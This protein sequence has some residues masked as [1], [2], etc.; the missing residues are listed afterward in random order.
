MDFVQGG[1][2]VRV[3]GALVTSRFGLSGYLAHAG[4]RLFELDLF[5]ERFNDGS[6]FAIA[7]MAEE[8]ANVGP[9]VHGTALSHHHLEARL[10]SS[11]V[12]HFRIAPSFALSVSLM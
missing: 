3:I 11:F 9:A 7:T 1:R 2:G 10:A 5:F 8:A 6:S 4:L 12:S